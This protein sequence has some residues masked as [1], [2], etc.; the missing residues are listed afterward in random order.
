MLQCI[1]VCCSALQC[2]AVH[3]SVLQGVRL[4]G[5]ECEKVS[6]KTPMWHAMCI[7]NTY[8]S[9]HRFV[10]H[11]NTM[12]HAQHAQDFLTPN[13]HLVE[14]VSATAPLWHAVAS[15]QGHRCASVRVC[16]PARTRVSLY[17]S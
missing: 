3:C 8:M 2:V 9:T 10:E 5:Q 1:A 12:Q 4:I 7:S 13:T 17:V 15:E 11:E 6:A 14:Q 16:S